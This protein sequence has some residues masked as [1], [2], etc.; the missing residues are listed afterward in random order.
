MNSVRATEYLNLL[1]QFMLQKYYDKRQYIKTRAPDLFIILLREC[2]RNV[3]Q[4]IIPCNKAIVENLQSRYAC[5]RID[6]NTVSHKEARF[7]LL[8][9]KVF[10]LVI[11]SLPDGITY[12][13]SSF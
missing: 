9:G 3:K 4:R 11:K 2:L 6:D 1:R 8:D 10:D 7:H 13:S 12:L 5:K